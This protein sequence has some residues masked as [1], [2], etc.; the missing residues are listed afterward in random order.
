M[1]FPMHLLMHFLAD[2]FSNILMQQGIFNQGFMDG[3]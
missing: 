1:H 2:A 3:S